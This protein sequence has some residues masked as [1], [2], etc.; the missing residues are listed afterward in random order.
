M[1]ERKYTLP[2]MPDWL[3]RIN[4][5]QVNTLLNKAGIGFYVEDDM[6]AETIA[7][8]IEN[9]LRNNL[10]VSDEAAIDA[11]VQASRNI[12]WRRTIAKPVPELVAVLINEPQANAAQTVITPEVEAA[13]LAAAKL[14]IKSFAVD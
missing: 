13:L 8:R 1:S 10:R 12:D 5:Q 6:T 4:E 3:L 11:V 2:G 9:I 14:I 7:E